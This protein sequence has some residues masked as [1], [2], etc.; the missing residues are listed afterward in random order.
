MADGFH[1]GR[2][3]GAF[4][5]DMDGTIVN[6]LA[7]VNRVWSAWARKHNVADVE[8]FMRT[9]HGIRAVENIRRLGLPGIEIER[10]AEAITIAEMEDVDGILP[11]EGALAFLSALPEGRWAIVT[12]AIRELALKR[13]A[14]AGLPVPRVLVTAEDV[15]H[16]KPAPDCFLLA[17]ERLGVP[18]GDC[19]VFED[20]PAGIKAAEAAGAAVAVVTATHSHVLETPHPSFADYGRLS[21][22]ANEPDGLRFGRAA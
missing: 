2:T 16:G 19:L 5:F 21:L 22:V 8:E 12:S 1:A 4:L 10:E 7:V 17:A 15:A 13:L 11:I 14:A 18:I 20:A 6:S 3:F 9:M